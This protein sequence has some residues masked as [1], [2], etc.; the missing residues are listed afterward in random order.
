MISNAVRT[1]A[2][3]PRSGDLADAVRTALNQHAPIRMWAKLVNVSAEGDVVALSGTVRTRAAKETA[4]SVAQN[5]AGVSRVKNALVVDTDVETEIARALA[6]D[7]RT[8]DS[9]PDMLVGVV[10]GT[11]FLNGRVPSLA[12][13]KAAGDVAA[14]IPGIQSVTNA[15]IA[16]EK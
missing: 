12:V 7:P 10:F 8:R 16:P 5:V 15:L 9:A 14:R 1:N 6:N 3:T 13:K 2:T 4:E 11:A